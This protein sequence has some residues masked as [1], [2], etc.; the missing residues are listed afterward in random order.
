MNSF[1][2]RIQIS[3]FGGGGEGGLVGERGNWSK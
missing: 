3:F 2:L 1:L